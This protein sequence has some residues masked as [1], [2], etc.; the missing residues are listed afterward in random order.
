VRATLDEQPHRDLATSR[1]GTVG[2]AIFRHLPRRVLDRL[3]AKRLRGAAR[4]GQFDHSEL[5]AELRG[6]LLGA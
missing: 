4:R 3:I 6:R 2:Y 1:Q 5:A